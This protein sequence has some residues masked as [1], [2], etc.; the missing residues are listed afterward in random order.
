MFFYLG[1]FYILAVLSNAAMNTGMHVSFRI[2]ISVSFF[3]RYIPRSGI[4]GLYGSS[5]FSFLKK[6]FC[7][8]AALTY[9]STNSI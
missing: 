3:F 1:C 2:S 9:I 4:A 5:I 7:T 6:L 8:V